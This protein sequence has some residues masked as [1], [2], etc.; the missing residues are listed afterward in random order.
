[1]IENQNHIVRT[2]PSQISLG[3]PSFD[4]RIV[5]H[6]QLSVV[7]VWSTLAKRKFSIITFALLIFAGAAAYTF[8]KTPQYEGVARLQIDPSRSSS[9]GLDESEKSALT[10]IDSRIKTEVAIIESDAV[11]M[12]VMNALQLYSTVAQAASVI[13]PVC[14]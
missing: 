4:R 14:Q 9:L 10:D 12:R 11:A 2:G 3:Q 5:A 1:M 8:L 6:Q 7:E 13:M